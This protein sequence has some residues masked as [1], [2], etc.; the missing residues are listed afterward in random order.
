M[1]MISESLSRIW[2]KLS[3]DWGDVYYYQRAPKWAVHANSESKFFGSG[4]K[5]ET[6]SG[7]RAMVLVNRSNEILVYHMNDGF[8]Y[9]NDNN[10]YEVVCVFPA[11]WLNITMMNIIEFQLGWWNR[12]EFGEKINKLVETGTDVDYKGKAG[13]YFKVTLEGL[14]FK[15]VKRPE[16]GFRPISPEFIPL[17]VVAKEQQ[18]IFRYHDAPEFVIH[19]LGQSIPLHSMDDDYGLFMV[20]AG[21]LTPSVIKDTAF[22]LVKGDKKS[23]GKRLLNMNPELE[24]ITDIQDARECYQYNPNVAVFNLPSF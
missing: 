9:I 6:W 18:V 20:P 5:I 24:L 14:K 4:T 17:L 23:W 11:E 8:S 3:F 15:F 10:A 16:T 19:D 12:K 13:W 1:F 2:N 22:N 7:Q 21:V